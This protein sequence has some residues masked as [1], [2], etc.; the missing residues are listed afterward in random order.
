MFTV[1]RGSYCIVDRICGGHKYSKGLLRA[2]Y[3]ISV[4]WAIV[5]SNINSAS[6]KTKNEK[7]KIW[8]ETFPIKV[9]TISDDHEDASVCRVSLTFPGIKKRK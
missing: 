7:I 4:A 9:L 6:N 3:R 1:L 5:P 2:T 8:T